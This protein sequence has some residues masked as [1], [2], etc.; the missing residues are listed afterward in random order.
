[1][2]LEERFGHAPV[3]ACLSAVFQSEITSFV[4]DSSRSRE[5]DFWLNGFWSFCFSEQREDGEERIGRQARG[6]VPPFQGWGIIGNVNPGLRSRTRFALGYGLSGFQP[7]EI[8]AFTCRPRR[9][10]GRHGPG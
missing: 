4:V 3:G 5:I 1:M 6:F 7:L 2:P 10:C 9:R 8:G